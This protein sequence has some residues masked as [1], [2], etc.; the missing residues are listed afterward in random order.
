[1][2]PWTPEQLATPDV[3]SVAAKLT[4]NGWLYQPLA[5]AARLEVAVAAGGVESNFSWTP[6]T[7]TLPALSVQE[8]ATVAPELSGPL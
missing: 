2:I 7:P 3:A 4:V 5:S 8:P 1:M 6:A